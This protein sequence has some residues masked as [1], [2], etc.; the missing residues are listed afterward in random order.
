[1]ANKLGMGCALLLFAASTP[2]FC[3]SLWDPQS[4][5]LFSGADAAQVGDSI[6][7]SIDSK[8]SLSYSAT[9]VDSERIT[10]ELAGGSAGTLFDFLP[11]GSSSGGQSLRGSED[12]SLSTSFA[13]RITA[14]DGAG[15]LTI[16]GSRTYIIQGTEETISI[17]GTID[18]EFV[19]DD[20]MVPLSRIANARISYTALLETG[21]ATLQAGDLVERTSETLEAETGIGAVGEVP[22]EDQPGS[23]ITTLSKER[24]QE[25][26]LLFINRIIDLVFQ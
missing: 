3:E 15:Q 17:S 10:L 22:L 23:V 6:L 1:M 16:Q 11:S 4:Q 13:A 2:L 7:I 18:P 19:R 20:R 21:V 24:Q 14:I 25:L 9:R 8:T 26:L 5:G 12:I